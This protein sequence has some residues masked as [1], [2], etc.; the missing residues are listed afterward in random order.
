MTTWKSTAKMSPDEMQREIMHLRSAYTGHQKL[1]TQ[2]R[3]T[4]AAYRGATEMLEALN[5]LSIE[6][7]ADAH[8]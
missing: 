7:I 1:L 8:Q 2:Y 5:S 3:A 6:T 4:V